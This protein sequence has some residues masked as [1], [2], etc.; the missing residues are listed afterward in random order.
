MRRTAPVI[1]ALALPLAAFPHAVSAQDG[2]TSGDAL[3]VLPDIIVSANRTPTA[4]AATGSSVSVITGEDIVNDGRPFALAVLATQPGVSVSQ[5]GAA[6]STSGFA[7]RGAPQQ[8]VRVVADGIEVS[9]PTSTQVQASLSGILLDG[10]GRIEVLKGSQSALYGGQA[11]AGLIDISSPRATEDGLQSTYVLE[12]G[13]YATARAAYS[14]TGQNDRGDFA[15]TAAHLRTDGFSNAERADGNPEP[16]GYEGTRLA[17]TGTFRATENLSL[18]GSAFTQHESGDFDGYDP[19]TFRLTDL[20]NT[21]D[22]TTWG[23]RAGFDLTT[24][25]LESRVAISWFDLDRDS[26]E[27]D[28]GLSTYDGDRVKIEYLGG[29][30]V[31][32]AL[33]LQ[34]G[35]E[36][37]RETAR[38]TGPYGDS[39]GD[40]EVAGVFGQAIWEPT[41][42]LT[43]TAALRNDDHSAF[44]SQPTGRLSAAWTALP[45][46]T[47]RASLGTGFRAPSLY[48]L[49]SPTYGN[50]DLDPETSVS[51]DLGVE[52]GFAEGR[53]LVSATVF[54]LDIDDLIDYSYLANR[55]EQV[56]GTA[57]SRGVELAGSYDLTDSV[58][59]VGNYT[60]THA[61]TATGSRRLRVPMHNVNL[62]VEAEPTSRL[63]AG[64]EVEYVAG[65]PDEPFIDSATWRSDYTLVNARIAY[66]VTDSAQVYLRAEN[67]FGEQYQTVEGYSAAGSAVYFGIRGTF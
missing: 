39:S 47:V 18:F 22:V 56:P 3:V 17:A 8:Y 9:D 54:L 21:Y 33:L 36:W 59:L 38:S 34:F 60:Y 13:T 62:G 4:A 48:E 53:G 23:A 45:E 31:S 14:L 52:Q 26:D 16:D 5:A 41:D 30:T 29:Y 7:I 20:D 19:T 11:V 51:A 46:T 27:E 43:L 32:D 40:T 6:G 50:A 37:A 64:V 42:T 65:L 24:G 58:T 1:A 12:G 25:A 63:K 61:R 55:F 67:L 66:A 10:V 44:G 2:D 35:A 49:F 57:K 15:L 28:V